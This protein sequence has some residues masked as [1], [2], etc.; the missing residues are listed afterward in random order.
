MGVVSQSHR[1][2]GLYVLCPLGFAPWVGG[3]LRELYTGC[4]MA[5]TYVG[6][7]AS[8]VEYRLM[9][10]RPDGGVS[11]ELGSLSAISGGQ[12]AVDWFDLDG[13]LGWCPFV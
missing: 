9:V 3:R 10:P 11:R 1:S 5:V 12:V 8:W 6:E 7:G 4:R 13:Y 2:V